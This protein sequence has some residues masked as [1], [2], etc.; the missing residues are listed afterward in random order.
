MFLVTLFYINN[1]IIIYYLLCE[2]KIKRIFQVVVYYYIFGNFV[3]HKVVLSH[4]SCVSILGIFY[5]FSTAFNKFFNSRPII[6]NVTFST[7]Y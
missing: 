4:T 6:D 1:I 7:K 2:V 5:N 3:E